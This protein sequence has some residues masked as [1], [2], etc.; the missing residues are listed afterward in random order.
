[1]NDDNSKKLWD[2]LSQDYDMGSYEEFVNDIQDEAKRRKLYDAISEEYDL[3]DFDGFSQQLGISK[4][5]P[6]PAAPQPQQQDTVR[7]DG[8]VFTESQLEAMENGAPVVQKEKAPAKYGTPEYANEVIAD[9]IPNNPYVGMTR[10]QAINT[11]R[12]KYRDEWFGQPGA[13]GKIQEELAAYNLASPED[14]GHITAAIRNS[15]VQPIARQRVEQLLSGVKYINGM[16]ADDIQAMIESRATQQAIE[17]DLKKLGIQNTE[18]MYDES[19]TEARAKARKEYEQEK[20]AYYETLEKQ[21]EQLLVEKYGFLPTNDGRSM[22]SMY[23]NTL[24]SSSGQDHEARILRREYGDMA[25]EHYSGVIDNAFK[26]AEEAAR[27]KEAEV[28][29]T[30]TK[31]TPTATS[32]A[33]YMGYDIGKGLVASREGNKLRDPDTI[34][35]SILNQISTPG[36]LLVENNEMFKKVLADANARNMDINEYLENYVAPAIQSAIVKKFQKEA[37][38]QSM[39]ANDFEYVMRGLSDDSVLGMIVGNMIYT[40]SQMKYRDMANSQ[41]GMDTGVWLNGARMAVGMAS[42]FWLWSGWGKIGGMATGE[43]LAMRAGSLATARGISMRAAMRLLEEEGMQ[44]LSKGVVDSMM[45]RIPQSMITM[46]GAEAT[47]E[48]VRGYTRGESFEDI[49]S[50]TFRTGVSGSATG[51]AFGVTGGLMG[52]LTSKLSGWQR[53]AGKLAGY[54]VEAGT[55]YTTEELQKMLSGED[56]FTNPWEGIFEANI[57]L[58]FIK[59]SANPMESATKLLNAIA[60]PVKTV[61]GM[62]KPDMGVLDEKDVQH[63]MKSAGGKSLLDALSSMRPQVTEELAER[64]GYMTEEKVLQAAEAYKAFMSDPNVPWETKQKVARLHGAIVP[65]PHFE[66]SADVVERDGEAVVITRDM[67][68]QC[69]RELHFDS[70]DEAQEEALVIKESLFDN[71]TKSLQQRIDAYDGRDYFG[72]YLGNEYANA[73]DKLKTGKA[74]TDEEEQAVHLYQHFNELEAIGNK[75]GKG[76]ALTDEEIRLFN[77]YQKR[78]IDYVMKGKGHEGFDIQFERE[79]GLEPGTVRETEDTDLIAKYQ[80]AME[81]YIRDKGRTPM[82]EEQKLL[83]GKVAEGPGGGTDA[84]TTAGTPGTDAGTPAAEATGTERTGTGRSERRQAAYDRGVQAAQNMG[85]LAVLTYEAQLATVRMEQLLPDSDPVLGRLR[86][87]IMK[88]I[89]AGNEAEAD[90]LI[91]ANAAYLDAR[92]KE[93]IEQWR[94][95]MQYDDGIQDGVLQQVQAYEQQRREELSRITA[96]DGTITQLVANDGHTYYYIS[97]DLNNQYGAVIVADENGQKSQIPVNSISNSFVPTVMQDYLN[98]EVDRYG[99][100]LEQNIAS[101]ANGSGFIPGSQV[102][103]VIAGSMFRGIVT[104]SDLA[105]NFIFQLEDGSQVPMSPADAQRAVMDATKMK[106]A[107]QLKQEKDAAIAQQRR[108]RFTKGIVGYAEGKADLTAKDSDPKAVAE[109][110][111]SMFEANG[112]DGANVHTETLKMANNR[113]DNLKAQIEKDRE[114]VR[115]LAAKAEIEGLTEDEQRAVDEA[116]VRIETAL[117]QRRK[118]GEIR[119]ALMNDEERNKFEADRQKDIK[120]AMD[121]VDRANEANVSTGQAIAVPTGQELLEKYEEKGDAADYIETLRQN[122]KAQHRD[123]VYPKLAALREAINDYRQGITDLTADELKGLATQLKELEAQENAMTLQSQELGKLA[124]SIGRLYAGREKQKLT[125]HEYKMQQLEKETNKDKKLKLAKEAFADDEE[126][127]M[128]LEDTEPQDVYEWIADNLGAGS[129]NWEGMQRGEHYVR[130]L[131]DELGKDKT[132]GVG[133]GSDTIGYN[134][135]LAPE[136]KGKGIDEVV[137]NIAEGS[138]YSTEDVRNALIDM[139]T[140]ASKPTDISHRI[141]DDRIARA[142]EIYEANLERERE[143]E[144]EAK[145]EALDNEL[146]EKMGMTP[147]EYDAYINDLERS[148]AEQEGYKTSDE[149]FNQIVEDYEREERTVGRSQETG[150]LGVQGKEGEPSAVEG[151]VEEGA[152]EPDAVSEGVT[153]ALTEIKSKPIQLI[154]S[155]DE[156]VKIGEK[157]LGEEFVNSLMEDYNDPQV[158]ARYMPETG[159]VYLFVD[160]IKKSGVSSTV[161][162][163]FVYHENIHGLSDGRMTVDDF[164][165]LAELIGERDK[166]FYDVIQQRHKDFVK[167]VQDEEIVAYFIQDIIH[168]G[169]VSYL[170]DGSLDF[171]NEE[172]NE[173][174]NDLVNKLKTKSNGKE[175]AQRLQPADAEGGAGGTVEEQP[176]STSE[177]EVSNKESFPARLATAKEETN[178][179]PTEEQKK[180]GNYKMGHISFGGYRMSIENPKGS[181]RSGKD[182]NGKAWSIEMK[183]TYGYIGKKYGTDGDHLDFF[184][185]DDADLDNW[186]GRVYVVDQKNEDGTFDEHKVMYGYPSFKAAKEA[187]LRNYEA[188]WWDKHVQAMTGVKKETF[189]KWLNDSD[190]KRKPFAEYSRTRNAETISDNVDQLL[191]D[192]R[193][194]A[195]KN[196]NELA[197]VK[198]SYKEGELEKLT[199]AELEQKKKKRVKDASTSRYFLQAN[200][201][202][203]GSEKEHILK[204]GEAQAKAD[205]KELDRVLEQKRAEQKARIEQQEIGFAV[206]DRLSDMGYDIT[207]DPSEVRRVRKAAEQD[208]SEEGKLRHMQTSDGTIYGFVYRGK[209][210][211]DI[212]KIDGNLP[213]HE[214]A[215]PWCEAFRRMNPEGWKDVVKTMQTDQATWDFVKQL[216]P[217]LKSDDDI[218]EEMIARGTGEKGEEYARKEYER[219][220]GRDPQ[221]KSKWSAI[222][223]NIAKAIQDFWKQIGDY[224]NIKYKSPEQVYDQVIRDFANKVNPRKKMEKWLKDR[225]KA[226]VEAV[227]SGDK[228]KATAIFDEALR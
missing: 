37:I 192:V 154:N 18:S 218:A 32:T 138:P 21:L 156:I 47:T 184:I 38:R 113:A 40:D 163:G 59:A 222:W 147:E 51:I 179:N 132:R 84:G 82:P 175:T 79:N 110:L 72:M 29:A 169:D 10:Q 114:F 39:P 140:S 7:A 26:I 181:T 168:N 49:V 161:V 166:D 87:D 224:L 93:A 210:Y 68:G 104:G 170:L 111:E 16:N 127:M 148:L 221:W 8:N 41:Y 15:Y 136:G 109:Y 211:L 112:A 196:V 81:A 150:A 142:E 23:A 123:E 80:E 178:T 128:V 199:I 33:S 83:E 62:V 97:G 149:Y 201:I 53:L 145:R 86:R 207:T 151:T 162:K 187:Y 30:G 9:D 69:V 73:S 6:Q 70:I 61:K 121:G 85:G 78:Y 134:Y 25:A 118:W 3:P 92:Q 50:N 164:A 189:D 89:E 98:E 144:E 17:D 197:N 152:G 66:V 186:N 1:M 99:A 63:I 209:M 88:A 131:R 74:L 174:I 202:E 65:P 160:K 167:E 44:Y 129:I 77:E 125:P 36:L 183:D 58:G 45:R 71:K 14:Y 212:R 117:Q 76:E 43:L 115:Q 2:A 103:F 198:P 205:I 180:A 57:K 35:Q 126:A 24:L 213:L 225:D 173:R 56:A 28:S 220:N 119:Q 195:M 133:K 177:K 5:V 182:A 12:D 100:E 60:H 135:F 52:R 137:H 13:Y 219:L 106:I 55:L 159:L 90:R 217:D 116:N 214:Y 64:E 227:E 190:H 46:G 172:L 27:Q 188:G 185:N 191:A 102:D 31:P 20:D 95:A 157:G 223:Q 194:R 42:D 34:L 193:E 141:V 139:L 91:E 54:E 216:N 155:K 130:G 107:S 176:H 67:D 204:M 96:P 120:K 101:L 4:P 153:E 11:V 105:G 75:L 124:S 146:M 203:E 108:E 228:A 226:Y 22:A 206:A 94:D 48:A 171:G 143:A 158:F 165:R 19:D 215:H 208:K 200:N 122:L